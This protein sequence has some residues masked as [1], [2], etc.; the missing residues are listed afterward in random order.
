MAAVGKE[1]STST[2]N[3]QVP[4][5]EEGSSPFASISTTM[6]WE[7]FHMV[8]VLWLN[9]IDLP[10]SSKEKDWEIQVEP[11]L[12]GTS[13]TLTR[14]SYLR[15]RSD[16]F[17]LHINASSVVKRVRL[18]RKFFVC[19]YLKFSGD[20][21]YIYGVHPSLLGELDTLTRFDNNYY[22]RA[23]SDFSIGISMRALL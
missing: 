23:R 8:Q 6:G 5:D 20:F 21:L 15:A 3:A 10:A 14:R 13:D 22:L 17:L 4:V 1:N 19:I 18:A 16:I 7:T 11:F 12:E 2:A 9:G